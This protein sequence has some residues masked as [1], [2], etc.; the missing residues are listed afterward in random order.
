MSDIASL[1]A[2]VTARRLVRAARTASLSSHMAEG[3]WPYGSL[4]LIACDLDAAPILLISRLAEHTRNIAADQRV[5]LLIDGTAGLASPLTG[6]RL[7]LLGR[8]AVSTDLRHRARF[9]ARHDDARTYADFGDFSF[10]RIAVERAHLV[11]GFGRIHWLTAADVSFPAG[12][13]E[14]AAAE[15]DVLAKVNARLGQA[16]DA[17]RVIGADAEGCD[18]SGDGGGLS[19]LHF[20]Q[21]V[22]DGAALE[23]EILAAVGRSDTPRLPTSRPGRL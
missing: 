11:A 16:G 7:T 4:V 1:P 6:P 2:P 8:V 5:A 23:R 14:L 20:D 22:A 17:R 21:P 19:R 12:A 13:A 15:A 10:Y 18:L 3:G 9:L